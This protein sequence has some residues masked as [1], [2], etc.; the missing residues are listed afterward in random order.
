MQ[1]LRIV[2]FVC[3]AAVGCTSLHAED[4]SIPYEFTAGDQAVAAEVNANFQA[5][6]A[7][8]A[9]ALARIEEL[10]NSNAQALNDFVEVV[11]DPYVPG[12]TIVRFAGVNV[13]VVSGS[14]ATDGEVNGLGN[15][16]V[17]YNEPNEAWGVGTCSLGE[18]WSD[19]TTCVLNGGSWALDHKSGSHNLVVGAGHRYSRHGGFAAGWNNT[20]TGISATVT[21]GSNNL[22]TAYLSSIS[23]GGGHIVSG[24]SSSVTGGYANRVTHEG[25]VVVGG[26]GNR[27]SRS[28][29]VVVGGRSNEASG[30]FSVVV[31]GT[32]NES[33]G[34]RSVVL[35]GAGNEATA[36]ESISPQ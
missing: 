4:V 13:Q 34:D 5:L 11:A 33:S 16:I 3:A 28:Q 23:G 6:A 35:G 1:Y 7:A 8:L 17:G 21:G 27:V 14:G 26:R 22:A 32:E 30:V 18:F 25:A 10:E 9:I 29:A 15:L 31:G 20:I 19:E 24:E 36:N 2:C 12:G